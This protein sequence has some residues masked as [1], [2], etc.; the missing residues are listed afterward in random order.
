MDTLQTYA[1]KLDNERANERMMRLKLEE[2]F[3]QNQKSHEDEVILRLKFEKQLNEM[4]SNFRDLRTKNSRC[5]KD[6]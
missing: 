1:E 4:H 5:M 3:N 2:E 6:L